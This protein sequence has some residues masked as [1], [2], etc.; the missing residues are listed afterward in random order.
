MF[1]PRILIFL[2]WSFLPLPSPWHPKHPLPFPSRQCVILYKAQAQIPGMTSSTLLY[3]SLQTGSG[4]PP[5]SSSCA[6]YFL[7]QWFLKWDPWTSSISYS[8]ELVG[9]ANS[10]A[11]PQTFRIRDCGSEPRNQFVSK[12]PH[13]A[14]H[15][16]CGESPSLWHSPLCIAV[17]C[18][19]RTLQVS[20]ENYLIVYYLTF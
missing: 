4:V 20:L 12:P 2:T 13:N 6:Q 17:T 7:H 10:Q 5:R 15:L 14:L 18:G 1:S 16:Q 8:W 19:Q 11:L 9:H 3:A